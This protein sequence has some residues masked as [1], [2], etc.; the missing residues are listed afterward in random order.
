MLS[1]FADIFTLFDWFSACI[2]PQS[3]LDRH[4]PIQ[5]KCRNRVTKPAHALRVR[6]IMI[7]L[8]L[9]GHLFVVSWYTDPNM[10]FRLSDSPL[11]LQNFLRQ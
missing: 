2:L 5:L 8:E 11:P 7:L 10:S 4:I 1:A 6:Y 9:I 3:L